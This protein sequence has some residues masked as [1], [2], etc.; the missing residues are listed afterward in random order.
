[1]NNFLQQEE[2]M[3]TS[4]SASQLGA[5][6]RLIQLDYEDK[7]EN[8]YQGSIDVEME[9]SGNEASM[10]STEVKKMVPVPGLN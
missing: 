4:S 7:L 2:E 6:F 5:I 3:M 10:M 9:E 1:M 8:D